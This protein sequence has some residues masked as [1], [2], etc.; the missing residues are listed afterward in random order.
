M[1]ALPGVRGA[2]VESRDGTSVLVVEGAP[3]P[4]A[5]L[6][7][8]DELG[9]SVEKDG[10]GPGR[11]WVKLLAA[12]LVAA[13]ILA[14]GI[15]AFRWIQDYYLAGGVVD[16][17]ASFSGASAPALGL[18][19]LFGLAVAFSPFTL[20]AVPA[21][22]GYVASSKHPSRGDALRLSASFTAGMVT[23]D[24]LMGALFAGVGTAAIS[25]FSTRLT[26][27]YGLITAVL[28]ALALI[29]LGVWRPRI[30]ALTPRAHQVR[31]ARGAYLLGF[32]FGFMACPGCTPLLLPVALGAAATGNAVYGAALMGAFALG[33][34]LPLVAAGLSIG[35]LRRMRELG[36][37]TRVIEKAVGVLL[38][39]GAGF[40][41]KELIRVSGALG[42]L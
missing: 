16:L 12:G 6:S 13:P 24:I 17:N 32:P 25:F 3:D 5:V 9:Y 7:R 27:W 36:R 40:F 41:L 29:L 38:L 10:K 15:Y 4:G 2:A 37:Y 22:M 33:R 30:P 14:A 26:L 28:L 35:V 1:C 18:A 23:V 20:A 31:S 8:L 42:L 19:F 34:G 21:V 39:A 11:A